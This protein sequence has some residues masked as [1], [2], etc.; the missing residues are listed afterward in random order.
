MADISY[1]VDLEIPRGGHVHLINISTQT[2][3]TATQQLRFVEI[4][5]VQSLNFGAIFF[6]DGRLIVRGRRK[7]TI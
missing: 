7:K 3:F 2:H 6:G 5:H 1:H 4:Q